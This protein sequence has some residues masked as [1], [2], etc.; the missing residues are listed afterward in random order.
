MFSLIQVQDTAEVS[1]PK[2]RG[3]KSQEERQG[4]VPER[5]GEDIKATGRQLKQGPEP[6][7]LDVEPEGSGQKCLD[8]GPTLLSSND[9]GRDGHTLPHPLSLNPLLL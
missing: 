8:G 1:K 7:E 4:L 3:K 2:A 6:E 9:L 5:E